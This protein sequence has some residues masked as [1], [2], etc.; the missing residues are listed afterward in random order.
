M[1]TTFHDAAVIFAG[2]AYRQRIKVSA[3]LF[4]AAATF[5]AHVRKDISGQTPLATLTIGDGLTRISDTEIEIEITGATTSGLA[6][7]H[8]V[9]DLIRTDVDPDQ[10]LQFIVKIPVRLPVTRGL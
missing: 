9:L 6:A 7:G 4:P 1:A 3:P 10:H 8:V 2:Y 5:S